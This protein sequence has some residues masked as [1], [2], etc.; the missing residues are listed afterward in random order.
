MI[1]TNIVIM[2]VERNT[3]IGTTYNGTPD[4]LNIVWHRVT[5]HDLQHQMRIALGFIDVVFTQP[6]NAVFA[7]SGLKPQVQVYGKV[8]YPSVRPVNFQNLQQ[9]KYLKSFS[10]QHLLFGV[11]SR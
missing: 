7:L 6:S 9:S 5:I 11:L 8:H 3:M 1:A 10:I 4:A 2:F